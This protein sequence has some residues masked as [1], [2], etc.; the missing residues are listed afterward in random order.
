MDTRMISDAIVQMVSIVCPSRMN[1]LVCL[2]WIIHIRW[3]PVVLSPGVQHP[4]VKFTIYLQIV[5]RLRMSGAVSPFTLY[6]FMAWTV[7]YYTHTHTHT[8]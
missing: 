7:T 3:V 5:P 6:A 2:S 4:V 1:S 8:H